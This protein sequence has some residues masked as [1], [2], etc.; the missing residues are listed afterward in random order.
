MIFEIN[1]N[2]FR[3]EDGYV[4]VSNDKVQKG[5]YIFN[6]NFGIVRWNNSTGLYPIASFKVV[7]QSKDLNLEGVPLIPTLF[8]ELKNV[9]SIK[10]AQELQP[11]AVVPGDLFFTKENLVVMQT[12]DMDGQKY[13]IVEL[14]EYL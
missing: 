9:K 14:I 1:K 4:G 10:V 12:F 6:H 5:D 7:F 2:L 11:V 3:H 8:D 13:I